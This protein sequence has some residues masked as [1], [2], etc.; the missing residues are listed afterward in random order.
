M[1]CRPALSKLP[2][3]LTPFANLTIDESLEIV[4]KL[5]VTA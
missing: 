1:L 2:F 5:I 3:A 4:A